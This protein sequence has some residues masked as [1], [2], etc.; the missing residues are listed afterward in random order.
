MQDLLAFI[1]V[2]APDYLPRHQ[3]NNAQ[4]FADV[5]EGMEYLQ[6]KTPTADGKEAL[7]QCIRNLRVAY[8]DFE[9]GHVNR[10]SRTVEDTAEMFRKARKY[11]DTDD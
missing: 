8:E 5:F 9:H 7:Q 1:H 11:I 10:A 6:E 4:V 2:Y 3:T